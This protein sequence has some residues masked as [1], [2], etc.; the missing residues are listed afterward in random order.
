MKLTGWRCW[1]AV[2][3]LCASATPAAAQ[4]TRAAILAAEQAEKFAHLRPYTPN[5]AEVIAADI[6][7]RLFSTPE[8][9]YPWFDSV[10]GGGGFTLGAGYRTF[11]G[12]RSFLD[13]RGLYSTKAYRLFEVATDSPGHARGRL[14]FRAS[15]GWRDATRVAYYGLSGDD[16]PDAE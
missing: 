4:D 13:V 3:A 12:D 9:V 16:T 7:K 14:D 8:G 1:C 15:A 2:M 6:Q 10:Y 11:Y 5:K